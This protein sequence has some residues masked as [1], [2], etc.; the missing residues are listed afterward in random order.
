MFAGRPPSPPPPHPSPPVPPPP[1]LPPPLSLPSPPPPLLPPHS[2]R[3]ST[4]PTP[5]FH[6]AASGGSPPPPPMWW[7]TTATIPHPVPL[8]PSPYPP[9][10]HDRPPYPVSI[11]LEA[12]P[13]SGRIIIP[14]P[15]YPTPIPNHPSAP[16][17]PQTRRWAEGCHSNPLPPCR[18]LDPSTPSPPRIPVN[19]T[20]NLVLRSPSCPC[21]VRTPDH[22]IDQLPCLLRSPCAVPAHQSSH[23][24]PV[25]PTPPS[26][27][28]HSPPPDQSLGRASPTKRRPDRAGGAKLPRESICTN[29]MSSARDSPLPP[30]PCA[31]G[32]PWQSAVPDDNRLR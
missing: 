1:I 9:P 8:P 19:A 26:P 15:T 14:D 27:P 12:P 28:R 30:V 11:P 31:E 13:P 16:P 21:T 32:S 4:P 2:V 6:L 10:P 22:L 20:N 29:A 24:P 23:P 18:V 17:P 5:P 3:S 7:R 25:P